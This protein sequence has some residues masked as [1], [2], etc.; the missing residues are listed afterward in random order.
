MGWNPKITRL[1]FAVTQ[2]CTRNVTQL[3]DYRDRLSK[4][5][6]G[7]KYYNYKGF[8][9]MILLAVCDARYNFLLYDV[10]QYGSTND[11]GALAESDFGKAFNQRL[12]NYPAPEKI[13]EC[14]SDMPFFLVGQFFHSKTGYYGLT[15]V[16]SE[17]RWTRYEVRI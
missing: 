14:P 5:I 4:K 9:S 13:P 3:L 15:P 6:T 12:F 11:S 1:G 10:G 2:T 8:F 16:Q 17:V 7:T